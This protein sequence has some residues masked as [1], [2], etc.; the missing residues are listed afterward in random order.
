MGSL[1]KMLSMY[2]LDNKNAV[3]LKDDM[4]LLYIIN[5]ATNQYYR[6]IS[7]EQYISVNE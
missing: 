6:S 4:P 3:V 2:S 1:E 5:R 7:I